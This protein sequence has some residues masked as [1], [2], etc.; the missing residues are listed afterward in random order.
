MQ[1]IKILVHDLCFHRGSWTKAK[2]MYENDYIIILVLDVCFHRRSWTK[3]KIM[4]EKYD[5]IQKLWCNTRFQYMIFA[6]VHDPR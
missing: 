2:I 5:A 4:Y 6:F 3:A 1:T